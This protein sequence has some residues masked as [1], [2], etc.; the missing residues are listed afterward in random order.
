MEYL[1]YLWQIQLKMYRFLIKLM[2]FKCGIM[3]TCVTTDSEVHFFV[4]RV[5]SEYLV[6]RQTDTQREGG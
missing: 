6:Q 5:S 3:L 4:R 2:T 1:F